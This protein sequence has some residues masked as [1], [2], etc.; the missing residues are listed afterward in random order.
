MEYSI[1]ELIYLIYFRFKCKRCVNNIQVRGPP[2]GSDC[3]DSL[4]SWNHCADKKGVVD[5]M[6]KGAWQTA[7]SFVYHHKSHDKQRE[8]V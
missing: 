5:V 8:T 2:E 6:L 4:S 7:V 3:R 1:S